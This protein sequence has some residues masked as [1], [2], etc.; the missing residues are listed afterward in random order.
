VS[1]IATPAPP[2]EPTR[3]R[4]PDDEGYIERDGVRVFWES[5]GEGRPLLLMPSW[6]IV[7]SRLWK[8]Q[9]HY[10]ARRFKVVVFDG[11]GNGR[12]DRPPG[13]EAYVPHEFTLDALA[14]MDAAGVE[15]TAV[16]GG[17]RGAQWT[18][19]LA[20]DHPERVAAAVFVAP[21]L[22]LTPWPPFA[23]VME[24]FDEPRA[25]RRK[26]KALANLKSGVPVMRQSRA[27]RLFARAVGPF[28][29]AEKFS[30]EYFHRDQADFVAWFARLVCTEA[31]STRLI[32]QITEWGLGTD[33]DTLAATFIART[34]G[35]REIADMCGA[36]ECPTLVIHGTDDLV[37]PFDWGE[38]LAEAL[39]TRLVTFEGA[40]H[41][42][43]ARHPVRFNLVLREFL[44]SVKREPGV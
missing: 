40:G 44:E 4:Y 7:T 6:S 17:S 38:A 14:V 21:A 16:V 24:N 12:S 23:S 9:I 19:E 35:P 8:A 20:S 31:H 37:T 41:A 13:P 42:P 26:A 15:R 30:A 25:W 27:M 34:P 39:G 18:L 10:L 33:P 32:E 11:R 29:G 28:E 5:Y 1:A 3:A 43:G 2:R 36:V 22:P